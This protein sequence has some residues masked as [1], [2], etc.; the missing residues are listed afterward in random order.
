VE[1]IFL[2]LTRTRGAAGARA[3]SL[4]AT[5]DSVHVATHDGIR[6]PGCRTVLIGVVPT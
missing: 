5:E 3:I 1:A 2:E 4:A 6:A